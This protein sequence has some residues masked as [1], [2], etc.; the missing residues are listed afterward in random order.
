M[1]HYIHKVCEMNLEWS[2]ESLSSHRIC[3]V[4]VITGRNIRRSLLF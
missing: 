2:F 3:D 1:Y 4:R